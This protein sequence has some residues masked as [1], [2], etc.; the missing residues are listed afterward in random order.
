LPSYID[1]DL[2]LAECRNQS[3]I[4][5]CSGN[6]GAQILSPPPHYLINHI[7]QEITTSRSR[8]PKA[9]DEYELLLHFGPNVLA[10]EGDEWKRQRKISA[11][12]FS[13]VSCIS[14]FVLPHF[15]IIFD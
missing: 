9:L 12:G 4:R 2:C 10:T 8:F 7:Q 15:S 3:L 5:R 13:D 1:S 14:S 6:Q 11:P